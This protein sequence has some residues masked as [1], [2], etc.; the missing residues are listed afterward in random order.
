M[1]IFDLA[2]QVSA[3]EP[4]KRKHAFASASGS[5]RWMK[6]T[7]SCGFIERNRKLLPEDTDTEYSREGT[8]AHDL[9]A[10]CLMLGFSEELFD[11][12][13]MARH[14]KGYVKH[15]ESRR[16]IPGAVFFLEQDV[17]L[18]YHPDE[19]GFLDAGIVV[20]DERLI[21]IDDLKYGAGVSVQAERNTQLA[22]Y[23]LSL[24][25]QLQD[26]F[27]FDDGWDVVLEIYQPRVE[28]EPALRQW[29]L[30]L[31]EL[32]AFCAEIG[33]IAR[34]IYANPNGGT[35]SPDDDTCR[36]C[37]AV[38]ICGA[39]AAQLFGDVPEETGLVLKKQQ[40]VFPL[41]ESLSV[42]Q[43]AH[44]VK[45]S[46]AIKEWLTKCEAAGAHR[47]HEGHGF[48]GFKLVHGRSNRKWRDES[49]VEELLG[50]TEL[51][52]EEWFTIKP[53]SP[54]QA[55]E[56]LS[57]Q[58]WEK[59]QHAVIKPEGKLTM[60]PEDDQRAAAVVNGAEIFDN[61]EQDTD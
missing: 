41:P 27:G 19:E 20:P 24:V 13:D 3:S 22:I 25:D 39:R 5:K 21:Y 54:A 36:F 6:C 9:A 56:K 23:G 4:A 51:P 45:W 58:D 28:G 46:P 12:K 26:L 59:V 43:L 15:V 34:A 31:G 52:Q 2:Q 7:A 1:D 18:F 16:D 42:E 49:E 57:K 8:K 32:R 35:F 55:Q 61:L 14:V 37:D 38:S 53:I 48:P 11:D 40:P 33:D 30:T 29:Q 50:M 10:A 44:V 47:L 60:V 17:P